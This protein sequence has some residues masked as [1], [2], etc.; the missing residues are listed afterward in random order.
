[1]KKI[2]LFFL[3]FIAMSFVWI[4]FADVVDPGTHYVD[5]CVK[6][7]NVEIDNYRVIVENDTVTYRDVYEPQAG[8][9]LEQHYKFWESRQYLLDKSI[10]IGEITKENIHDKAIQ[11]WDLRVNGRY[12][13]NWNPLSDENL[14]YKIVKNWNDYTLEESDND[15]VKTT[16]DENNYSLE[17]VESEQGIELVSVDR[18]IKFWIAWIIT[19]LI[20][21]IVLFLIAKLFR[22]ADQIPNWRL[23]LVW[24]LASTITLPLLRFVLPMFIVDGVEYVVIWELLVTIIEIF[25]IKYWLK[26]S[27]WKA[28]LASI[29]CNLCSYLLGILVF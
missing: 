22:K 6:L 8:N 17:I 25:I 11:I 5:R 20:E 18:L 21:T 10:D 9:C 27:R 19:I 14:T 15:S 24:I 26:V 16:E 28:I 7:Q 29:L 13:D 4:S 1:M 23:I 2:W 3:S 12:V